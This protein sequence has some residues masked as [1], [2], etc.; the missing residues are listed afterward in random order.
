M[1]PEKNRFLLPVFLML[2]GLLGTA[3]F[4]NQTLVGTCIVAMFAGAIWFVI[5]VL[6]AIFK[7]FSRRPSDGGST[8]DTSPDDEFTPFADYEFTNAAEYRE[9]LKRIH[10][11]QRLLVRGKIA[12]DYP[13]NMTYEGSKKEGERVVNDWIRLM[14]RAFDDE[15]SVIIDKCTCQNLE[16]SHEKLFKSWEAINDIGRRMKISIRFDYLQLKIE[17]LL[18]A[19]KYQEF[20]QEEKERIRHIR[21]EE[22]EKAKVEKELNERRAKIAKDQQHVTAELAAL[23]KR[24]ADTSDAS[25]LEEIQ[26]RIAELNQHAEKL[27]SDLQEVENRFQQARA[28]YVYVI[29]NIGSF[30]EDVYKIGMTRRL[31]P[32]ERIDELGDASVPFRFDVHALIFAEDAVSLETALHN[33]FADRRV[34]LVN[35]RKEFFRVTLDEIEE[36]VRRNYNRTVEFT[37]TAAAAEYH[38]TLE[39]RRKQNAA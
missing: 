13:V 2:G 31:E 15:C 20:K 35:P 17:E 24:A 33:R 21:E 4:D 39:L 38:E 32:Q 16:S 37:R 23:A 25:E 3:Y 7:L 36:C 10:E 22:R 27:V 14:L 12:C 5:S 1:K 29:S 34:N 30:G 18:P 6:C 19:L 8:A 9:E 26:A 28:G 11:Q